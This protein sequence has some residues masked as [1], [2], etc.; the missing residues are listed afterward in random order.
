MYR[1][2]IAVCSDI[3]KK[4]NKNKTNALCV[5]KIEFILVKRGGAYRIPL[6]F[7]RVSHFI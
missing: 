6:G 4:K 7:K 1:E 5:Q 2:K 3:R